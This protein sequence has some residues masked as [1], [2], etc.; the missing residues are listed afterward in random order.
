MPEPKT[1]AAQEV[2]ANDRETP[3]ISPARNRAIVT[4]CF[5]S[6]KVNLEKCAIFRLVP[7]TLTTF[8]P[9]L[10]KRFVEVICAKN[11]IRG[12]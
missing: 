7:W 10:V 12:N 4:L 11:S 8:R 6:G 2:A 9:Y 5:H 3:E 1:P